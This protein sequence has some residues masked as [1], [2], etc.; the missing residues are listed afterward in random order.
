MCMYVLY[1]IVH[2]SYLLKRKINFYVYAQKISIEDQAPMDINVPVLSSQLAKILAEIA[3]NVEHDRGYIL[4]QIF[5][6]SVRTRD[7]VRVST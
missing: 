7:K 5:P 1:C 4:A 6:R 2:L 3:R